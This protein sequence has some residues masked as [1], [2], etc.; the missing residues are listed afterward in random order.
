MDILGE[1]WKKRAKQKMLRVERNRRKVLEDIKDIFLDTLSLEVNEKVPIIDQLINIVYKFNEDTNGKEKLLMKAERKFENKVLEN[2]AQNITIDQ[3]EL[4]TLIC[5]L[6][7]V[8]S[9]FVKLI[10]FTNF[11]K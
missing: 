8:V 10:D 9:L 6:E 1:L 3:V 11:T 7:N 5:S 4:S 2:I